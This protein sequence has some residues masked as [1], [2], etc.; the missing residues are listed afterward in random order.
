ML[1][2]F[3]VWSGKQNRLAADAESKKPAL[4]S[5][6][7]AGLKLN[8]SPVSGSHLSPQLQTPRPRCQRGQSF[9][10]IQS[11][12]ETFPFFF[13]CQRFK[14]QDET[15]GEVKRNENIF[16]LMI[17][18]TQFDWLSKNS[19]NELPSKK[20]YS[21]ISG[22]QNRNIPQTPRTES[23]KRPNGIWSFSCLCFWW[24]L[25]CNV[26][27]YCVLFLWPPPTVVNPDLWLLSG[28]TLG[29][30]KQTQFVRLLGQ[31]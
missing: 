4:F 23:L 19:G 11:K 25:Q 17:C 21:F 14:A 24:Y 13:A 29:P 1:T 9:K 10:Q 18:T 22:G 28:E 5:F 30:R 7:H 3:S 12:F 26:N 6:L 20:D 8:I 31:N 16:L 27:V 2:L 15:R